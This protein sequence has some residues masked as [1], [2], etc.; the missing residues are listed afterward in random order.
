MKQS[1][2]RLV[3]RSH[4]FLIYLIAS[5]ACILFIGSYV[6]A[7]EKDK[8][9]VSSSNDLVFLSASELAERSSHIRSHPL[10]LLMLTSIILKSITVL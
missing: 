2:Q 8:E 10:R 6:Y 4:F 1:G 9:T 7:S 3:G 5:F